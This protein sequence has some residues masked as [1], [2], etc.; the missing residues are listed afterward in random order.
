MN[1]QKIDY[2]E[3]KENNAEI[4]AED[5]LVEEESSKMSLAGI[6]AKEAVQMGIQEKENVYW[7]DWINNHLKYNKMIS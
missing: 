7:D 6:T 2:Q 4:L 3:G 1:S 5:L